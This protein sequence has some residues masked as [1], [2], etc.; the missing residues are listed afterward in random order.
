MER[1]GALLVA[2]LNTTRCSPIFCAIQ[3]NAFCLNFHGRVTQAS[4]KNFQLVT[5]NLAEKVYLQFGK[6]RSVCLVL[7][8]LTGPCQVSKDRFSVDYQYPLTPFQ[9]FAICLSSFDSKLACE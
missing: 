4:V 2:L 1:K 3:L 9:A 5:D 6:V 8:P 7:G